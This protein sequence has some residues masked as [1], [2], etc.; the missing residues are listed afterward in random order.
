MAEGIRQK[1][2]LSK[3]EAKFNAEVEDTSLE[4]FFTSSPVQERD[5]GYVEVPPQLT[6]LGVEVDTASATAKAEVE[7]ELNINDSLIN[8]E[9]VVFSLSSTHFA[10]FFYNNN[11][12]FFEFYFYV[13]NIMFLFYFFFT[14]VF[15]WSSS[16]S[17]WELGST[18]LPFIFKKVRSDLR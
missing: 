15:E 17:A 10:T 12:S 16:Y 14:E 4:D 1:W 5:E 2:C 11:K 18:A 7:T 6:E 3:I 8:I 13:F 9:Y